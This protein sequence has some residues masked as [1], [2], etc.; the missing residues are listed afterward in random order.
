MPQSDLGDT[1]SISGGDP[2]ARF[3]ALPC[4]LHGGK[5]LNAVDKYPLYPCAFTA[6][7]CTI[8]GRRSR[9]KPR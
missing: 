2:G 7:S 5:P 3:V 6:I 1:L 8:R 9:Q 4:A